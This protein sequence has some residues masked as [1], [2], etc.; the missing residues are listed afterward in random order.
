MHV[1]SRFVH[2]VA[3]LLA[4]LMVAAGL[5][6]IQTA[7]SSPAHAATI[8]E[9]EPNYK[10]ELAD[11][12]SL[13]DTVFG[14]SST[15][16]CNNNFEDCD[17]FAYAIPR[18]GL[19]S[20]KFTFPAGLGT[21]SSYDV[22]IFGASGNYLAG[23]HLTGA[24]HDGSRISTQA[25][26]LPAGEIY[27]LV[28][29]WS[30]WASWGKQ[31]Q[32]T[33][34]VVPLRVE[35]EPN[36]VTSA[37]TVVPLGVPVVGSSLT[38]DCNNNFEDC[39]YFAFD[40]QKSGSYPIN[41]TF[42]SGLGTGSAYEISIYDQYGSLL[43]DNKLSGGYYDGA[44]LRSRPLNLPAGRVYVLIEG[45]RSW[46]SW[47]KSYRLTVGTP[48]TPPPS[49]YVP[50]TPSR[51]LDTRSGNGAPK[52]PVGAGQ[53]VNVQVTGRGGVPASGVAAVVLN[54]TGTGA[55][56][57]G[58]LVGYP[59][60]IARPG[61]SILNYYPGKDVA[62]QT[63]LK[64][65]TGGKVS[66]YAY[67]RTNLIADVLGYYPT[68][69]GKFI[70]LN[71]GRIVNSTTGQGVPKAPVSKQ[72]TVSFKV[73][74]I[75]SVPASA[76]VV[77]LNVTTLQ[78]AAAGWAT[79]WPAGVARPT[80]S[81]ANY[82]AGQKVASFVLVKV[83]AGG[84]VNYYSSQSTNV[85]V[86]VLGY[87]T[88]ASDIK[89]LTPSRL[90][91]TRAG[92]SPLPAGGSVTVKVTGRAGVPTS[93]VKAAVVN[94]TAVSPAGAG[95]VTVFPTGVTR[96]VTSNLNYATGATVAN[97][98]IAKVGSGG[99]LTIFTSKKAHIIVDVLGYISG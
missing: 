8:Y 42:S 76:T 7:G 71:P 53:T 13:G 31:Y 34:G 12:V 47:G 90:L 94:V 95:Y 5:A 35:E 93:G 22:S 1:S 99:N 24:D 52:A 55:A 27:V 97:S 38:P 32:L 48:P 15:P 50:L 75:G 64:V 78:P 98:V 89:A 68:A 67:T 70:P 73:G 88:S 74:G 37:A 30:R 44:W 43:Q 58:Y 36:N 16:D 86:D 29:G 19:A 51:I 56:A 3:R 77:A 28:E 82:V 62:N 91:D 40:I 17:Y 69:G 63:V 96:P 4:V 54:V 14:S 83:G 85:L 92:R 60:G 66:I 33:L 39:D 45:W 41:F 87:G 81:N 57:P 10:S 61:T 20:L 2:L 9:S 26:A 72:G 23:F 18:S 6:A 11:P 84:M 80:A 25:I 46:A 59:A 79:V 49:S 21:G 65:G